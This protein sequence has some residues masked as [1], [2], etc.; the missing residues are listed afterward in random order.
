VKRAAPPPTRHALLRDRRRLARV[1][2]GE[3]ILRH[4]RRALVAELFRLARPAADTRAVVENRADEAYSALIHALATVGGDET[5]S[6]G[7]P[8]RAIPVGLETFEQWGVTAVRVEPLAR[9]RR[10]GSAREL[11]PGEAGPA[12]SA[13]TDAFEDLVDLLLDAAS[14]EVALRRLGRALA[15]A[16][17]QL[18]TLERR[19]APD[20][21]DRISRT[22]RVLEER[23]REDH[24]RL[25]LV[26]GRRPRR[27][28]AAR[29]PGPEMT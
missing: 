26:A 17:R 6:L 16:S 4:R 15:H 8:S 20:L 28:F 5:R 29:R 25:K 21:E 10:S 2:R 11:A 23:E 18:N 19:V 7:W 12:A 1:R 27:R 24:Q 9:A 3:E 14:R 22:T 13:A